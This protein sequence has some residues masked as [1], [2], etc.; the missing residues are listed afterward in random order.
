[1]KELDGSLT[2]MMPSRTDANETVIPGWPRAERASGTAYALAVLSTDI[3]HTRVARTTADPLVSVTRRVAE[4]LEARAQL[5]HDTLGG[6]MTVR[7]IEAEGARRP[8]SS[9]QA[10]PVRDRGRRR[11]AAALLVEVSMTLHAASHAL[12]PAM[13]TIT[14]DPE[15]QATV[16]AVDMCRR[17]LSESEAAV[18]QLLELTRTTPGYRHSGAL[19][20]SRSSLTT[21]TDGQS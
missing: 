7:G 20:T 12:A 17:F 14:H 6:L 11:S 1:M 5:R 3:A 15:G 8:P 10:G 2:W 9:S 18:D 4:V 19:P 13:T 21:A 16:T